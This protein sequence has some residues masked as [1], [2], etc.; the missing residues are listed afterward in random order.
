MSRSTRWM[1]KRR[2]VALGTALL[3][4]GAACGDDGG[5]GSP[6]AE[7]DDA[8]EEVQEVTFAAAT[9]S[10]YYYNM[11]IAFNLGFFEEEGID[12]NMECIDGSSAVG[13]QMAAGNAETGGAGTA[14]FLPLYEQ[15]TPMY[16]FFMTDYGLAYDIVVPGP[17]DI[18]DVAGLKGKKI[19]ISA[20]AGAEVPVVRALLAEEGI[21]PNSGAQ[22]IEIGEDPG[23]ARLA[24]ERGRVDAVAASAGDLGA[25]IQT[26]VDAR[27]VISDAQKE[28]LSGFPAGAL[29]AT[30]EIKDDTDFLGRLGRAVAKGFLVGYANEDA[31]I[32]I[33]AEEIPE[34]F[35]DPEAGRASLEGAL[36]FTTAPQ[37]D[38]GTYQFSYGNDDVDLW[39]AYIEL[40]AN[41]GVLEEPFDME[42]YIVDVND[43]IN[44][45]DQAEI[46]EMAEGLESDCEAA[47]ASK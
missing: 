17:S 38:D 14:A 22:L 47:T 3:L 42:P 8:P 37:D 34:D 11:H 9:C 6:G 27:S 16:P 33:M 43:Q 26:G 39:N 2:V 7:G 24:L 31:A 18:Q 4:L 40:Y 46:V 10:A 12:V 28:Q 13:Q 29:F 36:E 23:A 25:L 41:G 35:V 19:G 15:G 5:G 44:D 45:F 1:G 30:E 21:D 20:L 32:C